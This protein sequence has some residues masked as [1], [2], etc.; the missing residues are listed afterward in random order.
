[1]RRVLH[2]SDVHFGRDDPR[3][4]R[5]VLDAVRQIDPH[6][7]VVSGDLTQ[8]ARRHQFRKARRFLDALPAPQLAVPGNH[9]VPLYDV[10]RRFLSPLGRYM[11]C[12]TPNLRP[13]HLDSGFVAV[14]LNTTRSFTVKD[15]TIRAD[16]LRHACDALQAAGDDR[17]KIV[18]AHHPFVG[19]HESSSPDGVSVDALAALARSGA[20]VFLTGH[21]HVSYA[22]DTAGRY[23]IA[24][25]TAV[26]VEAGTATSTRG[27]GEAN[28]FNLLRLER[29]RLVVERWL[30]HPATG[31]FTASGATT[32]EL[33]PN[34]WAAR[35]PEPPV[36]ELAASPS[37]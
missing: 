1:M 12:I 35:S 7:V 10:I 21:L 19:P 27:R 17:V 33:S 4:V 8:R 9:D 22:G 18:V 31:I 25:R 20:D 28:S 5:A 6:L 11:R 30:F 37:A 36:V 29:T 15:G 24:G 32:F 13:V 23:R 2:L 16:D 3:V 34:G 14:G 26:V